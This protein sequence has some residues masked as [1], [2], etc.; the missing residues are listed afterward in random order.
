MK[1]TTLT[2]SR[3]HCYALIFLASAGAYAQATQPIQIVTNM[4]DQDLVNALVDNDCAAISN[5][6][7]SGSGSQKSYGYFTGGSDY[8]FGSG[9]VLSTGYAASAAGPNT[10]ISG[11]GSNNWAGD[12]DLEQELGITNT[13]NATTLEF[14]F[15]PATNHISFDYIFASEE[16]T[17]W[18][19]ASSCNYSDGFAF[20]LREAGSTGAYQNLAVIPGTSTPVQV[21]TVRGTGTSCPSANAE[22]FDA[23]NTMDHPTNFNGQ[24]VVLTAQ[25]NVTAGTLY[26]IKLVI[27]DQGDT[28]YDA[29]VFLRANSFG[30]AVTLGSNRLIADGTAL[31]DDETLQLN[32]QIPNATGY[33]WYESGNPIPGAVNA[34]YTITAPGEYS[35]DAQLTDTCAATGEIT[36]EYYAPIALAPYT[37]NQCDDDNDGL[38][39]YYL[40]RI[41][42][43]MTGSHPDL[44]IESWHLSEAEAK[45][46]TNNILG[47]D[48]T[49]PFYNTAPNQQV[50]ARVRNGEGCIAAVPVTLATPP[51]G[52]FATTPIEVCDT[53]DDGI[54]T[55]DLT[56]LSQDILDAMPAGTTLQFFKIHEDALAYQLPLTTAS[57]T[58]TTPG[59]QTV[60]IGLFNLSG[61]HEVLEQELIV[62][63][64]G[65]DFSDAEL[66]L[67][68]DYTITLDAGSGFAT[69]A[70]NTDPVHTTQTL[71]V[72][73][74]GNYTVTVTDAN[75]CEGNRTFTVLLS[76]PAENV[77]YDIVDFKGNDNTVTITATGPGTYE[78]SADGINYQESPV[79]DH[80]PGG[81]HTFYVKDINGCA[82]EHRRT[83][84]ILDYPAFFT[85]NGDGINDTWRIPYSWFRPRIEVSVFDRYG[86][87][88]TKFR[89]NSEGWDGTFNG[90][91][92]P[93]TDYWFVIE[94]E[95]GK[96]VRGHF[97]MMR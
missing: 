41:G 66:I 21:T 37:W 13:F 68:K 83:L 5:V 14:D 47:P 74:P 58:N 71:N 76:G 86:K 2:L 15:I 4:A 84:Y 78:Y 96:K 52:T 54:Y 27:A 82:P 7:I 59:G 31:C 49:M 29:A 62:H 63:T 48:I 57:I 26:H 51:A 91:P 16:Y 61:C 38:T 87:F 69:Y 33:Q 40:G 17:G 50:Y 85:P 23:F 81:E 1:I 10:S 12:P 79:F 56:S 45:D 20:L 28:L 11:D 43:E 88:I 42:T 92:L 73:E 65:E 93:A 24:T 46:G 22:Y 72:S 53:D 3:I 8:P 36:V 60:Y 6:A 90:T 32:A 19:D 35:V 77:S 44:A 94:L 34:Q 39:A 97:S 89:G 64:F 80:L 9:I 30:S 70:W 67:C 95:N 75:G 18:P 25:A 55:F